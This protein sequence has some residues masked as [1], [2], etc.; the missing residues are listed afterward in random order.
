MTIFPGS[1]VV[2]EKRFGNASLADFMRTI[3]KLLV[4]GLNL[5]MLGLPTHA[6]DGDSW[7]ADGNGCRLWN[8]HPLPKESV[9]WSGACN[10][11]YAEGQGV[12][13]WEQGGK[14]G[15]RIEATYARGK[16]GGTGS[17]VSASGV[18]F[19]GNFVDGMPL[20]KGVMSW[21][22]GDRYVGDWVDGK[23]TGVGV[24]TRANGD[25]Y[26][27]DFIDGKWS[28]KG[29]FTAAVGTRYEG[30]W[31]DNKREGRGTMEFADGG[32][33]VGEWKADKPTNPEL[34]VRKSYS[35]KEEALGSHILRDRVAGVDVP[36]EKSYPELTAQEKL[37]VKELYEPMGENDE[38]PYPLHGPRTILDASATIGRSLRVRGWLT[39]AVTVSATGDAISVDE[40]RS[41]DPALTKNMAAVLMLEKY[42]PAVCKG[43]PCQMQYPFRMEF[44]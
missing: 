29:V 18:R 1:A 22:N 17:F 25:R 20:G 13:Q 7:T 38:P 6:D 2:I 14:L 12:V 30:N 28:G 4:A 19:E 9:T 3:T 16:S 23:R 31:V 35:I 26:E 11:G 43:S 37:R 15:T 27:G 10:D 36:I 44:R 8:P 39:L 40:L 21:P 33:Y 41:P 24:L 42:K 5:V 32:R 34:I